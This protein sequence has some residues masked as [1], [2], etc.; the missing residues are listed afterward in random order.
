MKKKKLKAKLT[1]TRD[2][3]AKAEAELA[4]LEASRTPAKKPAAIVVTRSAPKAAA[5][6][7]TKPRSA[8]PK[9]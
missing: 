8:S 3:L 6:A 4:A 1:K 9:T 2:K 7:R 5:R